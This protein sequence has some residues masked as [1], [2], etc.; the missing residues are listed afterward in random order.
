MNFKYVC[1][2]VC[3]VSL[4]WSL[5]TDG[6]LF[7][8]FSRFTLTY[9]PNRAQ[10]PC[11]SG[12]K[13][14]E[15]IRFSLTSPSL[16]CFLASPFFNASS[17]AES[18]DESHSK[19]HAPPSEVRE[20]ARKSEGNVRE[21]CSP[22]RASIA[23]YIGVCGVSG[24]GVRV[25]SRKTFFCRTDRTDHTDYY[26]SVA[27]LSKLP[28]RRRQ[29]TA[30]SPAN[31]R[32]VV[33]K[34]PTCRLQITASSRVSPYPP[35]EPLARG[36]RGAASRPSK[37]RLITDEVPPRGLRSAAS[38]PT[39]CR[40]KA[41]EPLSRRVPTEFL[42]FPLFGF[43]LRAAELNLQRDLLLSNLQSISQR[44]LL[45][46]LSRRNCRNRRNNN[47]FHL[48]NLWF[49]YSFSSMFHWQFV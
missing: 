23:L 9:S 16:F 48:F 7:E 39:R 22:S 40:L 24:E 18:S 28:L 49:R 14:R 3:F 8:R 38:S 37:C 29:I 12:F 47:P 21:I 32:F 6:D 46:S 45:F 4:F 11:T 42:L 27:R 30:S 26:L 31:Y 44:T 41:C 17:V 34:V 33:D 36:L 1:L 25:F 20:G 13:A 5:R 43:P 2:F 19:P 35:N 15:G 10:T